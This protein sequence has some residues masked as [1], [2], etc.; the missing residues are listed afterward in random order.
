MTIVISHV[1]ERSTLNFYLNVIIFHI[2]FK[3]S[4]IKYLDILRQRPKD[5]VVKRYCVSLLDKFGSLEY[6]RK[7]LEEL[8]KQARDEIAKLGGNPLIEKV[9]DSL[10]NWE[11]L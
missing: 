4:L 8:D 6:T 7:T 5:L 3:F 11:T 2:F 10:K 1:Y 9:L